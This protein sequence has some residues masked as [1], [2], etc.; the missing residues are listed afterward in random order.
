MISGLLVGHKTAAVGGD[1]VVPPTGYSGLGVTSA[2]P[3]F[4]LPDSGFVSPAS[5]VEAE[6]I[7]SQNPSP[8]SR[9]ST[10]KGVGHRDEL[11]KKRLKQHRQRDMLFELKEDGTYEMKEMSIREVFNYVQGEEMARGDWGGGGVVKIVCCWRGASTSREMGCFVTCW[12]VHS[13]NSYALGAAPARPVRREQLIQALSGM[14]QS[15]KSILLSCVYSTR[16]SKLSSRLPPS[17]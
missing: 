13:P 12:N 5:G 11:F 14:P 17:Q 10:R 2:D 4:L 9:R 6:G 3:P 16:S 15:T 7:V 8:K 1:E